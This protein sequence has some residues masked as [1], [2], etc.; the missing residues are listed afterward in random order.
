MCK[1]QHL[2]E[3][4]E[5]PSYLLV[6]P[7]LARHLA[8]RMYHGEYFAMQVDAHIVCFTQGWDRDIISQWKSTDNEMVV[9]STYLTDIADSIDPVTHESLREDRNMM[10]MIQYDGSGTQSRLILKVPSKSVPQIKGTPMLH[11]FWSAGFS[12]ARG[13]FVLQVPY[14]QHLPMVFQG[15]EGSMVIRGFTYGYDFYAPERSVTF[16]IYAIKENIARRGRHKFWENDTLYVG[17]LEKATA[18]LSGIT[19]MLGDRKREYYRVD[20]EKYGLGHVRDKTQY[21]QTFG[22]HPETRTVEDHLCNFVQETMHRQF[23]PHLREDGMG[24]DYSQIDF[25]FKD[26]L[27]PPREASQM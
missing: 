9:L 2:I 7:N 13:H 6:G 24:I 18:R 19:G 22:I 5:V 3:V 12:F 26:T 23:S 8:H 21:Y 16:H 4:Y 1:Y 15:E 11:P 17:A 14:D 20:E 27:T 25:E 10:C